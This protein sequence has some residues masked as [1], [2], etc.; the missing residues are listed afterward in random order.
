MGTYL[1]TWNPARWHRTEAEWQEDIAQLAKLGPEEFGRVEENA[2]WSLGTNYKKIQRGDR[3]FL[4]RVGSEPRGIFASG[5][6]ASEPY[7]APHWD[8]E[9]GHYSW[10]VILHWDTLLNPCHAASILSYDELKL[11]SAKQRWSPLSSGE[12]IKEE[13]AAKL[14]AEWQH[15][16]GASG[17]EKISAGK[18]EGA[19]TFH[20]GAVRQILWSKYERNPKA[21]KLCIESHGVSCAVCGFNFGDVYGEVGA[22]YIEVHHL[23]PLSQI[24]GEHEVDPVEDMVPICP[25]CH[26]MVH[27]KNPPYTVEELKKA[28][29]IP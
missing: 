3:L 24:G 16:G 7:E 14:E 6:A 11:I 26:A 8:E 29:G 25:N 22:N 10:Y 13:A 18:T 27:R 19:G 20:E 1:L 28:I 17:V 12:K 21:R 5:H 15:F 23:T 2:S 4:T 9:E